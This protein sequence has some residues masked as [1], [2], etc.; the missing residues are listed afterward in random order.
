MLPGEQSA[1]TRS[2]VRED[3]STRPGDLTIAETARRAKDLLV[4]WLLGPLAPGKRRTLEPRDR[5]NARQ[6]ER[7][8]RY[9]SSISEVL[10]HFINRYHRRR[11]SDYFPCQSREE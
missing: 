10:S 5:E 8:H 6:E 2:R 11:V 7:E 1:T 3:V 9:C 4:Y